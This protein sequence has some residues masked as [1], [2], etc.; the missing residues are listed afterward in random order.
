MAKK[1]QII[2]NVVRVGIYIRVSS[3]QQVEEGY[4]LEAQER[5]LRQYCEI[6]GWEVHTKY[7]DEGISGKKFNRPALQ[8]MLKDAKT[9][10]I[11][12]VVI[13]KLDRISRNTKDIL[14]ITDE[15]ENFGVSL[16]CI[17]D[18][19]DT[20][21]ATGKLLRTVLS[22]IAQFE[23]DVARERT[24]VAKEELALQGKFAGGNIPYGYEYDKE[25]KEFWINEHE[26]IVVE[27]IF[28]NYVDGKSANRIATELNSEGIATKRGGKWQAKQVLGILTNRFYTGQLEWEG[29]VN[30]GTHEAIISER[31]F[32][33][34]QKVLKQAQGM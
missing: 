14:C 9:G 10:L 34:V 19:I 18:N 16:V 12:K 8:Q 27:R 24:L 33:K 20:S 29:I 23:S 26:A 28:S 25:E 13:V 7:K 17:K 1:K 21:S 3:R 6:M 30:K 4:S 2:N 11:E 32:N 22:A 15:L 5:T 31:Q